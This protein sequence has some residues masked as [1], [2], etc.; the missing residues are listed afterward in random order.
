MT[1]YRYVDTAS[2]GG[3]GTTREHSGAT[4]AYASLSACLAAEATTLSDHIVIRCAGSADDAVA[5]SITGWTPGAYT[6]TIAGDRGEDDSSGGGDNGS[7]FDNDGFYDG[8]F[9]FSDSHYALKQSS[10]FTLLSVTEEN[11]IIDGIQV[12][13][14]KA[15]SGAIGISAGYSDTIVK[16]CRVGCPSG[17]AI[18][19]SGSSFRS[20]PQEISNNIVYSGGNTGIF[21][22]RATNAADKTTNVYNNTIYDCGTG[23]DLSSSDNTGDTW[24]IKNNVVFNCITEYAGLNS[25][26]STINATHNA[27]EGSAPAGH[28][29]N[30]IT[31]NATL[32]DD[33]TDPENASGESADDLRPVASG[34]LDGAGIG[35]STDSNSPTVDII[36]NSRDGS[37]PSIGAF[38]LLSGASTVLIGQAIESNSAFSL[39]RLKTQS[40]GQAAATDT[41]FAMTSA[42][43]ASI[44]QAVET[45]AA[46]DLSRSKV[47]S[48]LQAVE[49]DTAFAVTASGGVLVGQ[50]VETDTAFAMASTKL[51]A[52]TQAIETD[53]AQPFTWTKLMSAGL[54]SETD[55]AFTMAVSGS[56]PIGLALEADTAQ[57]IG[58]LKS[59][60][61]GQSS[62]SDTAFEVTRIKWREVGRAIETATAFTLSINKQQ[63]IGISTETDAA[64]PLSSDGS[65]TV[66]IG[67]ATTSDSAFSFGRNKTI[68]ASLATETDSAFNVSSVA[69]SAI[70]QA[71]ETDS[72]FS[73]GRLKS[74]AIGRATE[75]DTA[76]IFTSD[77]VITVRAPSGSGYAPGRVISVRP[78]QHYPTRM[79]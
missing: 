68:T 27:G 56:I 65:I 37:A 38:E 47:R 8:N 76:L 77:S 30:W 53:L 34:N 5:A 14:G 10:D 64:F 63:L 52:I 4:A 39:S 48:I 25:T 16:N 29:S 51:R 31:L 75:T 55:S 61:I 60:G 73:F 2:S 19:V 13:A 3:D 6:I 42:V 72:T 66:L 45:D 40:I 12:H 28:D 7:G 36:G 32:T 62:E 50:A 15:S 9:S 26:N 74:L 43:G 23:V 70:G 78:A 21:L 17:T 41:A 24:N 69:S 11:V 33:L 20:Y 79:H 59:L 49:T 44:G 22:A 57:V 54:A 35:N 1:Y 18:L 58:R 46:F 67:V 71:S